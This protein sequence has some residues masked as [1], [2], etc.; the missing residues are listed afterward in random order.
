MSF[1]VN[2]LIELRRLNTIAV[3]QD[4]SFA[5][6]ELSELNTEKSKYVSQLWLVELGT[7]AKKQITFGEWSNRS[8]KLDKHDQLYFLSNRPPQTEDKKH[9]GRFQLYKSATGD[10]V[11]LTEEPLGVSAYQLDDHQGFV[12]KTTCFPKIAREKQREHADNI[13]ENGPTALFY[14]TQRL[15]FWDHWIG[16][17]KENYVAY[18]KGKLGYQQKVLTP[19]VDD[20]YKNATW[21]L[22]KDGS[23]FVTS[24]THTSDK[25]KNERIDR[26]D[27]TRLRKIEIATGNVEELFAKD[28]HWIDGFTISN[29]DK[30]LCYVDFERL[31]DCFGR[32]DLVTMNLNTKTKDIHTFDFDGSIN[33]QAFA[34]D[35]KQIYFTADYQTT[36]SVFS[37]DFESSKI[38]QKTHRGS[39]HQCVERNGNFLGI[40]SSIMNPPEIFKQ[41]GEDALEVLTNLTEFTCS[42]K[43]EVSSLTTQSTDGS[44]IQF[45]RV[46]HGK[47][48][49]NMMAIHGGP[50]GQW[51]DVWH[52]RWNALV[53]AELGYEVFLPN[54]RG[55]TG[56]GQTF[57]DGIFGD[58]WGK[59]CYEDLMCVADEMQKVSDAPKTVTMGGS[60]GGYMTNWIATQTDRFDALMTH[61]GLFDLHQFYG[62]TDGPAYWSRTFQQNVYEDRN[63][64]DKYSPA[65]FVKNWKTPTLVIHGEK[66]YRVPISEALY[67]FDAL[68][69]FEVDSE[70][71]VFPDENHWILRPQ[72]VVVWYDTI[73]RFFD[74]KLLG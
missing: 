52:W 32:Y 42:E 9:A 72:N 18:S 24:Y 66:D 2:D 19:V 67:L 40:F 56:F 28:G 65:R 74:E 7:G 47:A 64:F 61:A 3:S 57:V 11:Q 22:S 68:Q 10:P 36:T 33:L 30:T 15:R 35:S 6:A 27:D 4:A 55:S 50:I 38:T 25:P 54:P 53:F 44:D 39:I 62:T 23:F 12:V 48:E 16:A 29:D 60:F 14:T 8:P 43:I 31:P 34:E 51:G 59:Q 5:V 63:A 49:R 13:S 46:G 58:T 26:L 1:N 69:Y 21:K 70:L 41:Q 37:Y 71:L 17:A 20:S 45:F 73:A